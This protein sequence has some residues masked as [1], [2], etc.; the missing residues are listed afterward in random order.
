M[1]TTTNWL[2][3]IYGYCAFTDL[4]RLKVPRLRV[5]DDSV[6]RPTG[7]GQLK[8]PVD[9]SGHF[10]YI[11]TYYTPEIPATIMSP[12]NVA[13]SYGCRGY[14]TFSDFVGDTSILHLLLCTTTTDY[15]I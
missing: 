9:S 1:D 11:H 8:V 13:R 7:M 6:Y 2:D 14:G 4:E 12:D 5:A 10:M 3:Y 15:K